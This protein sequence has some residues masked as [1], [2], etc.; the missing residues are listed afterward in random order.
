MVIAIAVLF[1]VFVF[2]FD[3][4]AQG[5]SWIGSVI[6]PIIYGVFIAY[7]INPLMM[8]I[9]DKVL[10]RF[11][12]SADPKP[13]VEGIVMKK[14]HESKVGDN[15]V[16]KTIERTA[17]LNKKS[18]RRKKT[19]RI[20]SVVL[21]YIILIAVIAG[22][23]IAI[24]PSVTQSIQELSHNMP[25]YFKKVET[26]LNEIFE[27]NPEIAGMISEEFTEISDLINDLMSKLAQKVE[28]MAGDIL[29]SVGSG[30]F[31]VV[32][33]IFNIFKNAI[34]GLILAI[35]LL[36]SKERFIAQIKKIF[37]AFFKNSRCHRIF[38]TAS[39]SNEIFK[40]YII[41]NLLDALIIFVAMAI[42]SFIMG[43]PYPMLIAVVCGVT[44]LIPF[45]GPFLGAI[46]CGLIIVLIDPIK[47]IWFAIFVLIIQQLDGNVIKPLLFG[48]TMGLP[49]IWVLV[50]IIVGGGM[51]GIGG[52]IL[53]APVFAVMYLL[54][55]EF[56]AKKLAKK[57]MPGETENYTGNISQFSDN[58]PFDNNN[59]S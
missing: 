25:E 40:Q 41:S 50:S 5:F 4:F 15:I 48:E 26:F 8:F 42:G 38:E 45:F 53:G 10:K 44:N 39:R 12:H 6:A 16:L 52:M 54:F 13:P 22:I 19:T 43:L 32:Y 49:A 28:P 2:K 27:N 21:T 31:S 46:P 24:V 3:T 56:I 11:K 59:N 36:Y 47:V 14:L 58:Y 23:V 30:I 37:F 33:S 57:N 20:L 17:E 29:G 35:Y 34:I 7:A 9:E 51:F 1:V 55:A 18:K